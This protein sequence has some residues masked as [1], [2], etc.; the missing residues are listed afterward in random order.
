MHL[1]KFAKIH[2]PRWRGFPFNFATFWGFGSCEV[3]LIW[4]DT[5]MVL[6]FSWQLV[7]NY[8][9]GYNFITTTNPW[10]SWLLFVPWIGLVMTQLTNDRH[11]VWVP[12]FLIFPKVPQ[13]SLGIFRVPRLP[14]PLSV[15]HHQPPCLAGIDRSRTPSRSTG[16]IRAVVLTTWTRW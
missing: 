6:G 15:H 13:S 12:S 14:L 8:K 3:A 16:G 10:S 1:P 11:Q 2:Q 9:L 4:P 5:W 7:T